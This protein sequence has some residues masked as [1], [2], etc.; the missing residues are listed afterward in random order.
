MKL[1]SL[2]SFITNATST[3]KRFPLAIVA[4]IIG[5][6]YWILISHTPYDLTSSYY[7]YWNVVMSCYLGMLLFISISVYCERKN[8][9]KSTRMIFR[10]V[11]VVLIVV[12]YF[13]LP[14]QFMTISFTRFLLFTLI[15]HLLISFVPFI[16]N[17]G[18]DGFWQ[19]NKTIFLRIL[20]AALYTVVLFLGLA[21]AVLAIDKLFNANIDSKI[22]LDLWILLS[23]IFN[24]WFFLTGFPSNFA[25]LDLKKDYPKGLKIFTQ[26]VLLPLVTVY[27]I[28]LYA[29]TFK[30]IFTAQWPTGWVS[31]LVLGFSI[32]GILSLL[33]IY[34]VRNEENNKWILI[35]SRFF[36]FALFPLIILFFLAV[37]RRISDYGITEQRYFILI[38]ALW[39][40]FIAIYFLVSKT[41]NIKIIPISLCL[42]ALASSFGPWGAF[43]VS[44]ANQKHHLKSLLEKYSMLTDGKIVPAKDSIPFKDR[45]KISSTINYLVDVHGYKTLQP[46]FVQRLDSALKKADENDHN[47]S[48]VNKILLLMNLT[49][50]PDYQTQEAE[51]ANGYINFYSDKSVPIVDIKGYDYFIPGF[52]INDYAGGDTTCSS[53]FLEKNKILFCF[54]INKKQLLIFKE[55]EKDSAII[56]DIGYLLKS[57][58]GEPNNYSPVSSEK[59]TM[60]S[61][62]TRLKAKIV[63]DNIHFIKRKDIINQ[64]G[65]SSNIFI[66]I[67]H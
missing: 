39:L 37:K 49:Y 65:C 9:G 44:L 47:S 59:M 58:T 5:S 30:I 64:I 55:N 67:Q 1:P 17:G 2:D 57:L 13:S 61:G 50:I 7:Y 42:L 66:S 25:E 48:R 23:G 54:D 11:G 46:Y 60:V 53:Y 32:G 35:F 14:S 16:A 36:Y 45:K 27:L 29:Y 38:L 56:F 4:V 18:V 31:Y 43:S 20:T 52:N 41:K 63:F 24:T 22:Y 3:F 40:L 19:Y 28:I 15:L 6:L 10:V 8:L 62:N 34:P 26:Y 51:G 33:L 12:Y 21:L